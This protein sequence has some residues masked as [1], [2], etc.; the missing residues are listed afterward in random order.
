LIVYD[1]TRL[2]LP[3]AHGPHHRRIAGEVGRGRQPAEWISGVIASGN[4]AME[5]RRRPPD[6]LFLVRVEYADALRPGS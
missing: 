1:V 6:G 4:R 5:G 2:G 3:A